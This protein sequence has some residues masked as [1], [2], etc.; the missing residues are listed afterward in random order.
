MGKFFLSVAIGVVTGVICFFLS[1]AF[2]ALVLLAIRGVSGTHPDMTLAYR[3]AIPVAG[4]AA[5]TGFIV[6][7]VR[8]RRR[9]HASADASAHA[10]ARRH[11]ES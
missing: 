4:M 6:S 10:P 7:L 8:G 5:I 3:A 11:T 9:H 2:L 1:V